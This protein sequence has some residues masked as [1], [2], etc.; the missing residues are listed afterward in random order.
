MKKIFLLPFISVLALLPASLALACGIEGKAARTDGSKVDG[1]ARVSTSWNSREAYPRDGYYNLEL[2][3]GVCGAN[4]EVY[5]NGNSIGRRSI[6][7]D[8]NA[9]VDFVL[10]GASD[11]PVR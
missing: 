6:P 4:I 1:T 7:G 11:M 8:G 2:G 3:D 9:R 5:V 10:K